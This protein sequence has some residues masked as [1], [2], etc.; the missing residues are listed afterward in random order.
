MRQD[1]NAGDKV[2]WLGLSAMIETF[3][4]NYHSPIGPIEII[5]SDQGVSSLLFVN[6]EEKSTV[7]PACLHDCVQQLDEYFNGKRREFALKLDLRG[8]S[9]QKRVWQ[10]LLTIPFGK[11][12]SYLDMALALGNRKIIRAVGGANGKNPICII[13]PCHRVIGSNGSL[14]G[15]GG[16]LWR[17]EWLLKFENR[18]GQTNLFESVQ[19]VTEKHRTLR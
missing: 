15:Y 18:A 7:I 6:R 3:M 8:T 10:E 9:F 19:A 17:K 5:G 1:L 12:V 11:T 13:V 4:Y 2:I 14:I 16:G